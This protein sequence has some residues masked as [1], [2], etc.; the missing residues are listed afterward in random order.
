MFNVAFQMNSSSSPIRMYFILSGS[1]Y[2]V[3]L[4]GKPETTWETL[5]KPGGYKWILEE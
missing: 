4:V 5:A 2:L 1:I 3:G